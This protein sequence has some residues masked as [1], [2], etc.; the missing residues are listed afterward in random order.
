MEVQVSTFSV[1][2]ED[3]FDIGPP[4]PRVLRR[5]LW[6]GP[7]SEKNEREDCNGFAESG[8]SHESRPGRHVEE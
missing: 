3:I 2:L 5:D 7:K 8:S 1:R 6:T 4:S